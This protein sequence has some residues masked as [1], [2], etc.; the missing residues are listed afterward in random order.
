MQ[1]PWEYGL[2][3]PITGDANQRHIE[4]MFS[5]WAINWNKLSPAAT[6]ALKSSIVEI[7]N[8]VYQQP[9]LPAGRCNKYCEIL[10][11]AL[12]EKGISSKVLKG[13]YSIEIPAGSNLQQIESMILKDE[14]SDDGVDYGGH[15]WLEV[16]GVLVDPTASQFIGQEAFGGTFENPGPWSAECYFGHWMN[17]GPFPADWWSQ[18]GWKRTS[19]CYDN[20]SWLRY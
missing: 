17:H 4:M 3:E 15:S 13:L 16:E 19:A 6:M 5:S 7:H 1:I 10:A 11:I 2:L 14:I 12:D 8:Q 20:I 9:G 18:G